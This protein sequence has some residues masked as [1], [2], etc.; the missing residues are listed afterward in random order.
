[1]ATIKDPWHPRAKRT[2]FG[3]WRFPWQ[4]INALTGSISWQVTWHY[5]R[6]SGKLTPP[7]NRLGNN[8]RE[9]FQQ[10]A[11]LDSIYRTTGD[12][13]SYDTKSSRILNDPLLPL[14][15]KDDIECDKPNLRARWVTP[16]D[17]Y[18]QLD[19][20]DDADWVALSSNKDVFPPYEPDPDIA[21]RM[22]FAMH[23]IQQGIYNEGFTDG[24]LP[25]QYRQIERRLIDS[26]FNAFDDSHHGHP[27]K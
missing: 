24:A 25:E 14:M 23:L 4:R 5:Q 22:L 1:M 16:L 9:T 15:L 8:A 11:N 10:I 13:M 20:K 12:S 27:P 18:P 3:N 17:Q 19:M 21:K 7:L 6:N 2:F 26:A